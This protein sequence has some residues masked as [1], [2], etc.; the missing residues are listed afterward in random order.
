LQTENL[1]LLGDCGSNDSRDS[2]PPFTCVFAALSPRCP[3]PTRRLSTS[4]VYDR[5]LHANIEVRQ[6]GRNHLELVCR[7][8]ETHQ[9]M[10]LRCLFF[11]WL[12]TGISG[13]MMHDS[14]MECAGTGAVLQVIKQVKARSFCSRISPDDRLSS[15]GFWGHRPESGHMTRLHSQRVIRT[16][17]RFH[18][19]AFSADASTDCVRQTGIGECPCSG[20]QIQSHRSRKVLERL[21]LGYGLHFLANRLLVVSPSG[22]IRVGTL[23]RIPGPTAWTVTR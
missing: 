13:Y 8:L 6:G 16:W 20:L 1:G 3:L 18:E 9:R 17:I 23:N 11:R 22:S 21:N 7:V 4:Q 5:E 2:T 19:I 12:K 14:A 10:Y 15:V